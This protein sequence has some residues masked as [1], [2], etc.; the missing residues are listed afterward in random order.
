MVG[1]PLGKYMGKSMGTSM[2]K[3]G[4]IWEHMGTYGKIWEHQTTSKHH[5]QQSHVN[6]LWSFSRD[7][8]TGVSYHAWCPSRHAGSQVLQSRALLPGFSMGFPMGSPW[9]KRLFPYELYWKNRMIPDGASWV[10]LKKNPSI[11]WKISEDS[12]TFFGLK[13]CLEALRARDVFC[14]KPQPAV[15]LRST[16]AAHLSNFIHQ[17]GFEVG[18]PCQKI[19]SWLWHWGRTRWWLVTFL[20]SKW[21][22]T[23]DN[24]TQHNKSHSPA[25][26]F[27]ISGHELEGF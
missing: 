23:K 21:R 11:Q 12:A 4:D 19:H 13:N 26:W 6:G 3:Y 24:Q 7:G 2:G 5:L 1:F 8:Q 17:D 9:G 10:P 16:R 25:S 18:E 22:I 20:D 27:D 15:D 14:E